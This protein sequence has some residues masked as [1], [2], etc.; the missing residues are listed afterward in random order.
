M[1]D[2][3]LEETNKLLNWKEYSKFKKVGI[4]SIILFLLGHL[5]IFLGLSK[6]G[7]IASSFSR[8]W[9]ATFWTTS[10]ELINAFT[11]GFIGFGISLVI[12]SIIFMAVVLVQW[13]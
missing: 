11:Y 5:N 9:G 4:I 12:I 1:K 2:N 8:P 10:G 7:D 3:K 13:L 6:G